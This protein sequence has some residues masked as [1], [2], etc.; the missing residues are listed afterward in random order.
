MICL[1][2]EFCIDEE[3]IST[4]NCTEAT[5]AC[6]LDWIAERGTI[7]AGSLQPYLSAINTFL[8][9]TGRDDA[10]AK[11]NTNEELRRVVPLPCDVILDILDD[12][13]PATTTDYGNMVRDGAAV[14]WTFMFYSRGDSNVSCRLIRDLAVDAHNI[15]IFVN[16]EKAE[17]RKRRD[18]FKPL[19]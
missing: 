1:F 9:H 14:C 18:G 12:L 2:V 17:H 7:G 15:N 11:L 13:A 4:L 16:R 8:R 10:P 6:Y 5:R 19:F 3:G